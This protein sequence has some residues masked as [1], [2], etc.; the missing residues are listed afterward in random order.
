MPGLGQQIATGRSVTLGAGWVSGDPGG[1]WSEG[2]RGRVLSTRVSG[3]TSAVS[4]PLLCSEAR[5]WFD[6]QSGA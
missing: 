4:A 5:S 3:S 6:A 2:S 1:V